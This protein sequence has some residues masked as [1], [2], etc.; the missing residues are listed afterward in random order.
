V[1]GI[2]GDVGRGRAGRT[3]KSISSGKLSSAASREP[4]GGAVAVCVRDS[5]QGVLARLRGRLDSE[6]AVSGLRHAR[7]T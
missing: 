1:D 6:T 5:A 4:A 2:R 7:A 3:S